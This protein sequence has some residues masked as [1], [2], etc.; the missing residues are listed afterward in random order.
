MNLGGRPGL[1]TE[2]LGNESNNVAAPEVLGA[3]YEDG[4]ISINPTTTLLD[5]GKRGE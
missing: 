3:V 2:M 5:E 4:E 1:K